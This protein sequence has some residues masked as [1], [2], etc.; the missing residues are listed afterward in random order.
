MASAFDILNTIAA[1]STA[2]GTALAAKV[3]DLNTFLIAAIAE[4]QGNK[5]NAE[6][7]IATLTSLGPS[8]AAALATTNQLI[9]ALTDEILQIQAMLLT[10]L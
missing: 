7:A 4:M 8:G 9:T 1:D 10:T 3:T 2:R 6:G 5:T